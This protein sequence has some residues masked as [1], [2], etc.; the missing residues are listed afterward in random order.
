[1]KKTGINW[2]KYLKYI[3]YLI[4]SLLIIAI[5]I[6]LVLIV[7]RKKEEEKKTA[8]GLSAVQKKTYGEEKESLL[9]SFIPV[10]DEA[11]DKIRNLIYIMKSKLEGAKEEVREKTHE[12]TA[13]GGV[14]VA[15]DFMHRVA[16]ENKQD[17][18][19]RNFVEVYVT[20]ETFNK[21]I[22]RRLSNMAVGTINEKT[23][24]EIRIKG[25]G[26]LKGYVMD[27][28]TASEIALAKD[29]NAVLLMD[30]W[31]ARCVAGALGIRSMSYDEFIGKYR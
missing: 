28:E 16:N 20:K 5:L 24:R 12:I 18:F 7:K 23:I 9:H 3:S 17:I 15:S 13:P 26:L 1:L 8:T 10:I 31:D 25:R 19:Q 6:A 29:R 30:D 4:I 22:S 14:V 27:S 21:F 11:G 2:L